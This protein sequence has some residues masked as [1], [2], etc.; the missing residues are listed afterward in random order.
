MTLKL[1]SSYTNVRER[2]GFEIDTRAARTE[3]NFS[4]AY[5]VHA[6]SKSLIGVMGSRVDTRFADDARFQGT[7]LRTSLNRVDSSYGV[8]LRQEL[9]P[10]TTLTISAL[11]SMS[12]FEF[13]PGRDTASNSLNASAAFAPAALI[14]GALSVGYTDFTPAD[15]SLPRYTGVIGTVDLTYVLLGSTRFAVL[16]NRGVQVPGPISRSR[17]TSSRA[18]A[19]RWRSR[20]SGRSMSRSAATWHG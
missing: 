19:V 7:N 6:F 8:N 17:P 9:T 15:P 13:S 1:D 4:G 2:P 20:S 10:L 14:R 3:T 5:D 11:R 12:R 16:G 18:S